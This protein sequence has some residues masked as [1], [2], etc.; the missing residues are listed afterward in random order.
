MQ[1]FKN[2]K[3]RQLFHILDA[4]NNLVIELGK[5]SINEQRFLLIDRIF[6][7]MVFFRSPAAI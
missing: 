3:L 2:Q 6:G 7:E 1:L 4:E 5:E